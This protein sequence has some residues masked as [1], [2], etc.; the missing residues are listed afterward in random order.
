MAQRYSPEFKRRAV[1][2]ARRCEKPLTQ[3]AHDL[4]VA[5][6]GLYRWMQDD[7]IE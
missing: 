1:E 4:G 6:S 3:I 2:L 5:E 7:D